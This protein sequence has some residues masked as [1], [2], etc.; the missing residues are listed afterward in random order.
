M[1]PA[2]ARLSTSGSEPLPGDGELRW[3]PP[4]LRGHPGRCSLV[5]GVIQAKMG[6]VRAALPLPSDTLVL[7]A[8][9]EPAV[10]G[11][12]ACTQGLCCEASRASLSDQE[13]QTD[14]REQRGSLSSW[15]EASVPRAP[16]LL[17]EPCPCVPCPDSVAAAS[18]GDRAS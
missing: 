13:G 5:E 16:A 10:L 1:I 14:G 18:Q 17:Q 12:P 6:E 11:R 2:W 15:S 8:Q 3:N 7:G 4:G 9:M